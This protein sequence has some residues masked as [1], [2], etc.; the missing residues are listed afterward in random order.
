M[1]SYTT[2]SAA[3]E[4]ILCFQIHA[5]SETLKLICIPYLKPCATT[6]WCFN[7]FL[8]CKEFRSHQNCGFLNYFRCKEFRCHQNCG[9]LKHTKI[10]TENQVNPVVVNCWM[11]NWN[12]GIV[13]C[14]LV[15]NEMN[16]HTPKKKNPNLFLVNLL[17][18]F[19]SLSHFSF[20]L[21]KQGQL[22]RSHKKPLL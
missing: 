10:Q 5:K 13:M 14:A 15:H 17:Y 3:F 11:K 8:P 6:D 22:L 7:Y 19:A 4:E 9:F 12:G 16:P 2:T 1:K 20:R 18:F 21:C